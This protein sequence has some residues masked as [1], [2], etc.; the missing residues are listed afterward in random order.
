METNQKTCSFCG[1]PL[2]EGAAVCPR[3]GAPVVESVASG[4]NFAQA[5]TLISGRMEAPP[6]QP[7]PPAEEPLPNPLGDM[8]EE[9][10][11]SEPP[12][13]PAYNPPPPEPAYTAPP[14]PPPTPPYIS[15][16]PPKGGVPRWVWGIVI[17]VVILFCLCC[18]CL[19]SILVFNRQGSSY[20]YQF[21]YNP[22]PV[23]QVVPGIPGK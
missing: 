6:P 10:V 1:D 15:P 2:P 13:E 21:T 11:P 12:A 4:D 22:P 23:V 9:P 7:E 19:G 3:C 14:P 5:Q 18:A 8:P 17:A 16:T 20:Q